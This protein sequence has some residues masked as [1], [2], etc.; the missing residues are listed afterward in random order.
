M[1][2]RQGSST[3]PPCLDGQQRPVVAFWPPGVLTVSADIVRRLVAMASST[4]L[5]ASALLV[6][7]KWIQSLLD[8]SKIWE[9]RGE[10]TKKRE[11]IALACKGTG[12]LFGEVQVTD[13]LP[14]GVVD[15]GGQL[16]AVQGH[17]QHFLLLPANMTKHRVSNEELRGFRYR[18][19]YAWVVSD[20]V[21]YEEPVR[22]SH[23]R[24][25]QDWVR[26]DKCR[27]A[28][29]TEDEARSAPKRQRLSSTSTDDRAD[30]RGLAGAQGQ[31]S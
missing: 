4:D 10:R 16:V 25:A 27:P 30:R 23:P 22:Y 29:S 13:C 6:H 17:E 12:K 7:G 3:Q 24:G 31:T 19:W 5:P 26:L 15:S 9:L 11:R 8:G 14:V 1:R 21:H 28:P 20:P 18:R 2:V